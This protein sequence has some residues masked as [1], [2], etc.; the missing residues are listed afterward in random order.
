MGEV[1]L[2]YDTTFAT[3]WASVDG[4]SAREY[5]LSG[6]QQVDISHRVRMRYLAGLTQSMRILWLGRT[7]EIISVLERENRTIHELICQ[8]VT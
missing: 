7:L 1:V 8:E 3:V 4:V 6:Q 5:L 2:A